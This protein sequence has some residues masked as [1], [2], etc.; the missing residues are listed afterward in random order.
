MKLQHDATGSNKNSYLKLKVNKFF[1]AIAI[2]VSSATGWA[3]TSPQVS[4][5]FEPQQVVT[6]ESTYLRLVTSPAASCRD[7]DGSSITLDQFG[8]ANIK[9]DAVNEK[10]SVQVICTN[11]YGSTE[12]SAYL[13]VDGRS[14][15]DEQ[16]AEAASGQNSSNGGTPDSGFSFSSFWNSSFFDSI[17]AFFNNLFSS[18]STSQ[19]ATEPSAFAGVTPTTYDLTVDRLGAAVYSLP[20]SVPN[21][22]GGVKPN[23]TAVYNSQSPNGLL[24]KG[25]SLGGLSAIKRCAQT[26]VRDGVNKAISWTVED[27]FCIDTQRLMLVAGTQGEAESQYK[28]E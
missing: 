3:Q 22:I 19:H 14:I 13:R 6:G 26:L 2:F 25:G 21:G 20:I 9:Y 7:S 10:I 11:V 8:A 17:I 24:G 18:E 27:R 12:K 1:V 28:T 16:I 15:L 23:I 4:L 5:Y